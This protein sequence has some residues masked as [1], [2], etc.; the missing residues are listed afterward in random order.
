[1]SKGALLMRTFFEGKKRH[2]IHRILL[3]Y[4]LYGDPAEP[5][6]ETFLGGAGTIW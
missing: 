1:M 5:F 2:D 3:L 6:S 4:F